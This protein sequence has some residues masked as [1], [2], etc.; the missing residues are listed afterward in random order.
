MSPVIRVFLGRILAALVAGGATYL[1]THYGI[2]MDTEAQDK[3]V[4]TILVLVTTVLAIYGGAHK[5]INSKLNP[6]DSAE[7]ELAVEGK[8]KSQQIEAIK[9][10]E[11]EDK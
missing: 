6:A 4:D 9:I 2:E 1:L 7:R 8:R 10:D 3:M 5:A 11:K